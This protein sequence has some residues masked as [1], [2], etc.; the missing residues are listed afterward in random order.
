MPNIGGNALPIFITK[1]TPK[2]TLSKLVLSSSHLSGEK[3]R[4]V[5]VLGIAVTGWVVLLLPVAEVPQGEGSVGSHLW[6]LLFLIDDQDFHYHQA[7]RIP[8][9]GVFVQPGCHREQGEKVVL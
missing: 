2:R 7:D 6:P 9:A 3:N 1:L 8:N 4:C 5:I